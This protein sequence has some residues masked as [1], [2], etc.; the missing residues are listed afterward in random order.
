MEG[1]GGCGGG[2]DGS[3][4]KLLH[5]SARCAAVTPSRPVTMRSFVPEIGMNKNTYPHAHMHTH[6]YADSLWVSGACWLVHKEVNAA[7]WTSQCMC[8][9]TMVDSSNV[10]FWF[11]KN[12]W[13]YAISTELL[14]RKWITLCDVNLEAIV[15]VQYAFLVRK[16]IIIIGVEVWT[17]FHFLYYSRMPWKHWQCQPVYTHDQNQL[18]WIHRK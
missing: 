18:P 4:R 13:D 7:K 9:L 2:M 10:D 17:V 3:Y 14:V 1:G 6:M 16:Q 8:G 12:D 5:A 15:K 11:C